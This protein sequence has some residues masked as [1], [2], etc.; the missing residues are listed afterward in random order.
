[1]VSFPVVEGKKIAIAL[2][3]KT[4]G[5]WVA[6]YRVVWD[7]LGVDDRLQD[8]GDSQVLDEDDGKAIVS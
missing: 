2:G 3:A 8:D 1:M 5:R 7:L 6:G 4:N